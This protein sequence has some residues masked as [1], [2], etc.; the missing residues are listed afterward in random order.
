VSEDRVDEAAGSPE[1]ASRAGRNLP[2]AVAV[3][4]ALGAVLVAAL[5]TYR[6]IYLGIVDAAVAVATWELAGA[7]RRARGVQVPRVPLLLGGQAMIWLTWPFGTSGLLGAVAVTVLACLAWRMPAGAEGYLR[8]ASA[9]VFIACYVPLFGAFAALLTE[10]ADGAGRALTFMVCVACS[11][12][13]G[14]AAGAL[15]GKHP[16]AP[17]IS[18]KKSWEGLA[19]S[20]VVGVPGGVLTVLLL[21]SSAWWKGM[22]LG[23]AIVAAATAGDLFESLLKRDVGIKDMGTLM[24]GHGGLMDRMDSMLPSAVLAWLLLSLLVPVQL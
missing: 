7:L 21:L 10:P 14:Y 6:H 8:D 9:S 5:E 22:I 23:V 17:A 1:R 11:D 2:A 19:G 24:P 12:T 16:M 20:L 3:G 13:G 18:P 4:L 15:F